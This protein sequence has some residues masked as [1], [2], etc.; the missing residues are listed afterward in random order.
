VRGQEPLVPDAGEVRVEGGEDIAQCSEG[1]VPVRLFQGLAADAFH[2]AA[3][4][5]EIGGRIVSCWAAQGSV[6]VVVKRDQQE[7]RGTASVACLPC[8]A[9]RRCRG[10]CC[11][12][13]YENLKGGG[14]LAE[15]EPDC[16]ERAPGG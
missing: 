14:P 1:G 2:L 13:R 15:G 7:R 6:V 3:V 9:E 8:R 5:A 11:G 4:E 12:L 10:R 16:T